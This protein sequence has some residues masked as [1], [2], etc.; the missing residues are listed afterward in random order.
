MSTNVII[1]FKSKP[2]KLVAFMEI[3]KG[4]KNDLPN[5]EGCTAVRIFNDI[6]EPCTFTLV[7]TW[8]SESAHKKHIEAF[9]ASGG[10]GHVAS[11]LACD[12]VSGYYKAV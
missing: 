1:T 9:V 5:V 3:L 6:N 12:P 4:V 10:W 7:E 11:H 8:Q 2:E